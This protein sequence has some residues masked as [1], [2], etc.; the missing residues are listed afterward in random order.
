MDNAV[1]LTTVLHRIL[2]DPIAAYLEEHGIRAVVRSDD[3]GG[4]DP[5]L[6]FTRGVE[7]RVAEEDLARAKRLLGQM[8]DAVEL[9]EGELVD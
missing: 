6:A 5:A 1:V 9:D 2:G 3:C 7:V 8:R 4:L